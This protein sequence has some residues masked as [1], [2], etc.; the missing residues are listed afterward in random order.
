MSRRFLT[1]IVLP[2]DP[3]AAMEAATKQYVDAGGLPSTNAA[4]GRMLRRNPTTNVAE[5]TTNYGWMPY[6]AIAAGATP[7]WTQFSVD[8]LTAPTQ[9]RIFSSTYD[10]SRYADLRSLQVGDVI[11]LIHMTSTTFGHRLLVTGTPVYADFVLTVPV[12]LVPETATG[13][14]APP[15]I[16]VGGNYAVHLTYSGTATSWNSAWG[17]VAPN[18]AA[19]GVIAASAVTLVTQAFTAVA[20]RRYALR[21]LNSAS[22]TELT[23]TGNT[24]RIEVQIDGTSIHNLNLSVD[25]VNNYFPPSSTIIDLEPT[26]G[27]HTITLVGIRV[28]GTGNMTARMALAIEDVG[29]V[30]QVVTTAPTPVMQWNSAWGIIASGPTAAARATAPNANTRLGADIT[31]STIAGRRYRI[32]RRINSLIPS[33]QNFGIALGFLKGAGVVGDGDQWMWSGGNYSGG[34]VQSDFLGDGTTWTVYSAVLSV[35]AGAGTYVD[36]NGAGIYVEDLGPVSGAT[37]VPNPTPAWIAPTYQNSWHAFNASWSTPGY[38][39]IGD[40][41]ELRGMVSG[42]T[43]PSV[44]FTLP[45]GYRPPK[46]SVFGTLGDF[47][48]TD[49]TGRPGRVDIDIDGTVVIQSGPVPGTGW[50][51]LET[52]WF[53]VT[54]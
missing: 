42:G 39:L 35:N 22:Y 14:G 45:V 24:F 50:I 2:A 54:P 33:A 23:A 10:S 25:A 1:P 13:W 44:A 7:D 5:W 43:A 9:F 32:I 3:A 49:G 38:R 18:A 30:S 29:P 52:F 53:S 37:P 46:R 4:A 15:S 47:I 11:N 12:T 31:F 34:I 20:G 17:V 8:N 16:A 40:K 41:V 26:A 6:T 48:G 27:T 51:T 19:N 21:V 36:V 28:T